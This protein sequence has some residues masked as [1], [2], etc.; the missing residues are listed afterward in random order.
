MSIERFFGLMGYSVTLIKYL[1]EQSGV[2]VPYHQ[3]AQFQAT[4]SLLFQTTPDMFYGIEKGV[5]LI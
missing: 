1:L 2:F 5:E 4:V 3:K